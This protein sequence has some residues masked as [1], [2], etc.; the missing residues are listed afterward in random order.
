MHSVEQSTIVRCF[1]SPTVF[2]EVCSAGSE[3]NEVQL[4]QTGSRREIGQMMDLICCAAAVLF[5]AACVRYVRFCD[6]L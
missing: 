2:G 6:R 5:F 3:D 4:L 1:R